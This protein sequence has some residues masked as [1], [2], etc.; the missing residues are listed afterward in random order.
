MFLYIR[1]ARGL[2]V[3]PVKEPEFLTGRIR[4]V[5][6]N[7]ECLIWTEDPFTEYQER[8]G[9]IE[10]GIRR[11]E[12]DREPLVKLV[13]ELSS[14]EVT[15]VRRWSGEFSLYVA[16]RPT[17]V[18]ASHLRLI[19][20]LFTGLP[21][22][23]RLLQP[24]WRIK[25]AQGQFT[26]EKPESHRG[27]PKN[28]F[29][30]DA[31]I[32]RIRRLVTESVR[33]VPIASALLLSGGVDSSVIAALGRQER[34]QLQ[35]FVFGLARLVQP[36]REFENDFAFAKQ[37]CTYLSCPLVEIRLERSCLVGNAAQAVAFAETPRGTIIDDCV[38]LREVALVL[39]RRGFSTVVM[40]EAADDLFGG[41][42]FALRYYRGKQLQQYFLHEL[43][44]S[45]P[46][47]LCIIQKM[48]E[49]WGISVVH[50]YWTR[51]LKRL[52]EN[53]PLDVRVDSKRLMKR[54][55]RD[56][57]GDILPAEIKERPKGVTRDT[58]QIRLVMENRF[59][60]SR[61][62]YRGLF[63]RIFRDGFRWPQKRKS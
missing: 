18:I 29:D 17:C 38:A 42:K 8:S 58:T 16:A 45:L 3:A 59:G 15:A 49:P 43:N 46:N 22:A 53:L 44:V 61:E 55:L 13:W 27:C 19:A 33:R 31:A 4:T 6:H 52:T 10:I 1:D 30:Y 39:K 20:W 25:L 34:R 24:G 51:E 21:A 63:R 5:I 12:I 40:G 9:R 50:P 48:F 7:H 37:M 56:A 14:G 32:A 36:Q 47:E 26:E 62:R 60:R 28:S 23:T 41:F 35:P 54:I 11:P 2:S 57:F